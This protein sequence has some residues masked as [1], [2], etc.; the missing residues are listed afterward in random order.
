[1]KYI[2]FAKNTILCSEM[3]VIAKYTQF[4]HLLTVYPISGIASEKRIQ[5]KI[6]IRLLS[7]FAKNPRSW[8]LSFLFLEC[9]KAISNLIIKIDFNIK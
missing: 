7:L 8:I 2:L 9:Q 3:V 1:M 6:E 4:L 5:T